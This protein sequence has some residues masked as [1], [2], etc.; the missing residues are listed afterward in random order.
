V[1]FSGHAATIFTIAKNRSHA[2][3]RAG[4]HQGKDGLN[5]RTA[6]VLILFHFKWQLARSLQFNREWVSRS[7]NRPQDGGPLAPGLFCL[8]C[9]PSYESRVMFCPQGLCSYG[10]RS[11]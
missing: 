4:T 2:G 5:C 9:L 7:H 11:L 6:S 1:A 10:L 8:F 3:S